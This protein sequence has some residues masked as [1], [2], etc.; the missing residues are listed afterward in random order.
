MKKR[1]EEVDKAFSEHPNNGKLKPICN[2]RI[3][4]YKC[5]CYARYVEVDGIQYWK[6]FYLVNQ[7]QAYDKEYNYL[8]RQMYDIAAAMVAVLQSKGMKII[9]YSNWMNKIK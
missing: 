8:I 9:I 7:H 4:G 1:I 6:I 5:R 3:D 2:H